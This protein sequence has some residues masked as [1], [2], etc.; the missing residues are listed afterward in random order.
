MSHPGV[1]SGGVIDSVACLDVSDGRIT[2][3]RVISNPDK[4]RHV[5]PP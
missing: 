4:L 5:I 1:T 3:I 2:E